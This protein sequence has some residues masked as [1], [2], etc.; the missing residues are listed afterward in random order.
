MQRIFKRWLG[1]AALAMAAFGAG[2]AQASSFS[3]LVVFGDSLTDTG[4]VFI[5]TGGAVPAA[6]YFNGRFSNG[7]V[8]IDHLA[9][10]LGLPAGAVASF[11]GGNN[12]AFGG[13]RSGSGTSPVPGLLAQYGGLYAPTHPSADPDALYVIVGGG[14]DMRDARSAYSGST[15]AD[16]AGRQ[17]AAAQAAGNLGALIGALAASGAQHFLVANLPD[18]GRTP[19]AAFLGVQAASTDASVRFNDAMDL[20]VAGGIGLG[21]D[22]MFLDLDA[23][24]ANLFANPGAYGIVNTLAPCNGFPGSPNIAATACGISLFSDA[25][26]PSAKAHEIFGT[27]ALAAVGVV[28]EPQTLVLLAG[29]L[30]LLGW[31]VRGRVGR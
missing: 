31:R 29:G 22:V 19:E 6:P 12:Y 10:G 25:L 2:A 30:L 11:A 21:L 3:N 17:A 1:S 9:A 15:A 20:V 18:L 13:A 5:A 8:W 28:P 16:D 14:N 24:S 26:H 7:P 23:L 27:A 4:N